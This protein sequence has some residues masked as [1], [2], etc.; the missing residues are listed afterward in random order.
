MDYKVTSA[1]M[2]AIAD[3]IRAKSGGES[4]L[5][6]PDGFVSE[7]GSIVTPGDINL[8]LTERNITFRAGENITLTP[9]QTKSTHFSADI[10]SSMMARWIRTDTTTV[11]S[12]QTAGLSSITVTVKSLSFYSGT[13]LWLTVSVHNNSSNNAQVRTTNSTVTIPC[14]FYK[15]K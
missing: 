15:N 9:G 1:Q 6:F 4:A 14:R 10:P 11:P 3:A 5:V 2:T 13:V 12:E 8:A 7:A